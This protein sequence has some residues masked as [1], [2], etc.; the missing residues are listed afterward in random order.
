[1]RNSRGAFWR[2]AGD[3]QRTHGGLPPEDRA[4]ISHPAPLA[5]LG[6]AVSHRVWR[7]GRALSGDLTGCGTGT[8]CAGVGIVALVANGQL[9]AGTS[10]G[11]IWVSRNNGATWALSWKDPENGPVTSLWAHPDRMETALAVVGGRVLRSTNGGTAWFDISADLPDAGWT[12]VAGHLEGRTA[13]IGGTLGVYYSRVSLTEPGPAGGWTEITGALT[14][15][16]VQDLAVEPL[17]GRLY[18]SLP[19]HGI[20]WIR[21]PEVAGALR[22]LRAA[23]LS[24]GPAAPGSLL[25]ILGTE[26]LRAS[27]GGRPAPILDAQAG[28]TQAAGAVRPS[29]V[30]HYACSWKRL[31]RSMSWRCRW[32]KWP[33]PS[34]SS[35]ASRLC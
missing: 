18:A 21:L 1:M 23:D 3:P 25:T 35:T 20:F 19:G 22:A 26:A 4:R 33:R 16:T 11:R 24:L 14:P 13:Y 10:N 7:D 31:V 12:S 32:R 28:R 5:P 34:S 27:A 2:V 6:Y 15:G 17:R 29:R 9:W 8:A 30:D